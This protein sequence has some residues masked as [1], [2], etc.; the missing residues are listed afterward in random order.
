VKENPDQKDALIDELFNTAGK[1][2][3]FLDYNEF[4]ETEK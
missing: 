1:Y 3:R 4:L 2:S